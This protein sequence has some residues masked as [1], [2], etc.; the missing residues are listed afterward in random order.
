MGVIHMG[1]KAVQIIYGPAV[2][3]IAADVRELIGE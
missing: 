3:G 1:D 2:G